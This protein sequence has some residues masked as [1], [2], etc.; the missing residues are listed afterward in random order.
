MVTLSRFF[1]NHTRYRISLLTFLFLL[2]ACKSQI[3]IVSDIDIRSNNYKIDVHFVGQGFS[4]ERRQLFLDAATRWAS[5]IKGDLPSVSLSRPLEDVCGFGEAAITGVIDDLL[6]IAI[7]ADIDGPGKILGAAFPSI[8]RTNS[9]LTAIGCMVFDQA[10]LLSLEAEGTISNVIL[11]EMGHVLGIGSL[12]QPITGFNSRNLLEYRTSGFMQ[13]CNTAASFS[14]RPSFKG[15]FA[16]QEF[17]ALG[18]QGQTPVEDRYGAGTQCSHWNEGIFQNELMTGFSHQGAM[19][20]S[21]LSI[22]SLAD[23]G[24]EVDFSQADAYSLPSCYPA[25]CIFSQQEKS[26]WELVLPPRAKILPNGELLPLRTESE[27]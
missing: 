27:N 13:I 20:L 22:A 14:Q 10:D 7:I 15:S 3:G 6:I 4:S 26:A 16:N 1:L 23:L 12:W 21:R 24:Y 18:G 17:E 8:I 2:A 25:A 11:H 9:E 5:V 19:P